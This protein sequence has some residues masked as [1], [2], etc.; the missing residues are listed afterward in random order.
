MISYRGDPNPKFANEADSMFVW[1]S[2]VWTKANEILGE[3]LQEMQSNPSTIPPSISEVLDE[4]P[5]FELVVM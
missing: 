1:R 4:L 5:E 2:Q 3:W